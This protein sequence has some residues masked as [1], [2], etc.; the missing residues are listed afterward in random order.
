MSAVR[1]LEYE[2]TSVCQR[3]PKI[4]VPFTDQGQ[5]LTFEPEFQRQQ[6][7]RGSFGEFWLRT[8]DRV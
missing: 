7:I 6:A 4:L 1:D 2:L 5:E 3:N 8:R